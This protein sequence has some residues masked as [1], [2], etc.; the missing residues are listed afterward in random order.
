V[1]NR[2]YLAANRDARV[3]WDFEDRLV[4]VTKSDGTVVE[5]VYDVDGVLVR[6]AVNGVG[7]D[8]LVDTSG[9]LSHVVAEVDGSGAVSVLYVR[10]GDMLLEE[11]RGGVAK[12]YEADGLGSVRGLLDVS[13]AKTD[14]YAY[15]AFGST[16][17]STGSD[18]N[19]YRFAGERLVDSVGF[20]QNR[21]RWLDTRT[22]RFVSVDPERGALG[23]PMSMVPYLY[24]NASPVSMADPT[25]RQ[26]L[27]EVGIVFMAA[28]TLAC[29]STPDSKNWGQR[30]LNAAEGQLLRTQVLPLERETL[31]VT[32]DKLA[33]WAPQ[34]RGLVRTWFGEDSEMVRAHVTAVLDAAK[35]QSERYTEANFAWRYFPESEDCN[36]WACVNPEKDTSIYLTPRFFSE[37]AADAKSQAIA[38]VHERTHFNSVGA[39]SDITGTG[40]Q[41]RF[42]QTRSLARYSPPEALANAQSY[43]LFVAC[44]TRRGTV[45]DWMCDPY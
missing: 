7:T 35:A 24:G 34:E 16:L 27:M 31:R 1:R 22:G 6:T 42:W 29:T 45:N 2:W 20:Y 32:L 40:G 12:M 30:N 41:L 4:K 11:V 44:S 13:G 18:E 37:G 19:P 39:T 3:E 28:A 5:N 26:T 23:Y 10:A 21:A 15:E 9:G 43:A 38:L 8:Y 33:A 14:T 25:G 17:S 36:G